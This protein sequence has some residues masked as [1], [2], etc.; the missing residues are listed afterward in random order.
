LE[1]PKGNLQFDT[2]EV[3]D[4][5]DYTSEGGGSSKL[6]SGRETIFD[7]QDDEKAKDVETDDAASFESTDGRQSLIRKFFE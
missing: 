1:E 6:K 2:Q 4:A 7:S 5:V 3:K